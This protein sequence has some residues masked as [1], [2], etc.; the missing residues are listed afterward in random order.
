[1][2]AWKATTTL[3]RAVLKAAATV[4]PAA[5]VWRVPISSDNCL[6]VI[7]DDDQFDIDLFV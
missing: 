5:I 6:D 2:T 7:S 1:M 3:A 4:S